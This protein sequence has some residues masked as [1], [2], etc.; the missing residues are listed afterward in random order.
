M[1]GWFPLNGAWI[2]LKGDYVAV[3]KVTVLFRSVEESKIHSVG[4]NWLGGLVYS[5]TFRM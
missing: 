2:E 4:V 5:G 3:A 1:T